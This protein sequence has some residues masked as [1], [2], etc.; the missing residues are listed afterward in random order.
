LNPYSEEGARLYDLEHRDVLDDLHLYTSYAML[1]PGPLLELGC[2]SGRLMLPLAEAG[3]DVVGVDSSSAMLERARER[4]EGVPAARWRLV[5]AGLADLSSLPEGRFGL[6]Y[7]ALNTWAHLADPEDALGALRGA[8]RALRPAGTLV[9]DLED[10][11]H[12]AP[13]RGELLLAGVWEDGDELVTKTV[14]SLYD[15]AEGVERVTVLWDRIREGVVRRTL[16]RFIQR[17]YRR[18]ELEQ[19][20]ARAGFETRE[21][22]GSWELE[23]YRAQGDRL[24][25]VAD[26]LPAQPDA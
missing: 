21:L 11:E 12:R 10:P 16:A 17:P 24:I 2:G 13:G 19:L 18:A 14:A 20:L 9:L 6:A 5:Q 15:P 26:R 7:C 22:L 4:L 3:H 1:A 8:W 23:P 25:F